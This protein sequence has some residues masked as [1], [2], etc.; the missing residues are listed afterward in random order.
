MSSSSYLIRENYIVKDDNLEELGIVKGD[1]VEILTDSVSYPETHQARTVCNICK[2]K[3]Y[4]SGV[5]NLEY[6]CG[7]S[8]SDDFSCGAS[9]GDGGAI[10][11]PIFEIKKIR[12]GVIRL[13]RSSLISEYCDSQCVY[14]ESNLNCNKSVNCPFKNF[15]LDG[16]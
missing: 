1:L 2:I 10:R 14:R 6:P 9:D 15:D 11:N 13:S 8:F 5:I 7:E 16:E 3:D 12:S 4:C